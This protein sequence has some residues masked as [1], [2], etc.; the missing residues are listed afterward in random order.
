MLKL[1]TEFFGKSQNMM[2]FYRTK[3]TKYHKC[4]HDGSLP[5]TKWVDLPICFTEKQLASILSA[6][7]DIRPKYSALVVV[8]IGGFC[9]GTQACYDMLCSERNGIKLFFAGWNLGGFY[10]KRLLEELEK[11][12]VALCVVSKS[13][14]TMETSLAFDLLKSYL[15]NRYGQRYVDRIY[16][17]TGENHG[18]LRQE[19]QE[20]SYHTF[21]LDADIGGRYSVLTAVGLLPLAAAGVDIKAMLDGAKQAYEDCSVL[22]FEQN[23]CYLYAAFRN[24]MF[25][26]GKFIEFFSFPEPEMHRFGNWLRQLFAES[27]GKDGCGI[28]PVA[29]DYSTDLHSVGQFLEDGHPVFFETM[30]T[31]DSYDHDLAVE[32]HDK[33]YNEYIMAATEAVYRVRNAKKTPLIRL[34]FSSLNA[35]N[36]GY[37]IYFFEKAC[38]MSCLLMGVNPFDQPGVEAYKKEM[39][40]LLSSE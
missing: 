29:L 1:E 14:T 16:V 26:S 28:F 3:I 33:T 27:E 13:G 38:A 25:K 18:I 30:L 37:M 9:L 12:E 32:G 21:A 10:H 11:H 22:D 36:V 35:E 23:V 8:G 17:V 31:F 15:K 24:E 39:C 40:V 5:M 4:L 6:A 20:K 19:A 2:A 34:I 7:E